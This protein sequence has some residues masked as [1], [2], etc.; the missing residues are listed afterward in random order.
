MIVGQQLLMD[1][2]TSLRSP[3]DDLKAVQDIISQILDDSQINHN[4]V[5]ATT[6]KGDGVVGTVFF[7]EG[8]LLLRT[9]PSHRYVAIELFIEPEFPHEKLL[10]RLLKKHFNAEKTK[11][12]HVK[13]GDLG[14]L[15]DMKPRIKTTTKPMR[16]VK[17]TSKKMMG[18]L[19][20][21]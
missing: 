19:R 12:T 21:K 9:Y 10:I 20:R 15:T 6:I 14:T 8:H 4:N 11:I 3:I 17:D 1:I 13:R 18:L 16:R 2:Y 7:P 5:H